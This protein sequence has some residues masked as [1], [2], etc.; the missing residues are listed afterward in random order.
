MKLIPML[1]QSANEL[2]N[3]RTLAAT[4]LLIAIHTILSMFV[5]I[6]LSESLRISVSF[7]CKVVIG[8]FYGPVVGF[9]SG[10]LCDI[11]QFVIKPAGAFN[12]GLTFDAAL[13][14]FLYGLFFYQ[15]FP[16][17]NSRFDLPSFLRCIAGIATNTLIVNMLLGT[18]WISRLIGTPFWVLFGPR[19]LKN[20]IQLPVNILL[21]YLVLSQIS[22]IAPYLHSSR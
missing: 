15:R 5:S 17:K 21:T 16:A 20:L 18:F 22:R 3:P 4:A 6:Q 9:V 19:A 8:A 14:G 7:I 10:G 11:V 12:P 1:R 13:E 2:Q